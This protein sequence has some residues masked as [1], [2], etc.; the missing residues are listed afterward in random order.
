MAIIT[1]AAIT[2]L[3]GNLAKKGLEKAFETTGEKLTE[4]ALRWLKSVFY[5][6]DKP[7]KLVDD[8][9]QNPNS[10]ARKKAVESLINIDLEDAP[11]NVQFLRE[12]YENSIDTNIS[13]V[14]SK[15][16]NTGD[17]NTG[18]GSVHIGDSNEKE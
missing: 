8:L 1:T 9:I 18:G 13:I 7:K 16:V 4:G 6:D 17:I 14:K 2:A 12:V 3:V 15:N 10:D 11:E 5:E